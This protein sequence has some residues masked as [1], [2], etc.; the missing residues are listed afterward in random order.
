MSGDVVEE[1]IAADLSAIVK[2][3][4][5]KTAEAQAKEFGELYE[6][7]YPKAVRSGR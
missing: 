6:K 4:S 7:R 5:R 1:E 3:R 2:V